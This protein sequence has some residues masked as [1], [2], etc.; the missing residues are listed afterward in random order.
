MSTHSE[1]CCLQRWIS[2]LTIDGEGYWDW[3]LSQ[4]FASLHEAQTQRDEFNSE[5][6]TRI[7]RMELVERDVI[8]KRDG[9]EIRQA[10]LF[11]TTDV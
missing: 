7:V 8:E 2:P 10:K 6:L 9:R 11:K 1:L 3:D 4:L 5:E